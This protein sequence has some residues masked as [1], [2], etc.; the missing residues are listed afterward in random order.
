ME[1][2]FHGSPDLLRHHVKEVDHLVASVAG[3]LRALPQSPPAA[4]LHGDLVPANVL[5]QGGRVTGVLNFGFLTAVG[6][7][8]FDAAITASIF[9]MYGPTHVLQRTCWVK[10]SPPDSVTTWTDTVSIVLRTPSSHIPALVQ[11]VLTATSCGALRCFG[12]RT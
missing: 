5:V 2:R 9:D 6:D 4:L 8:Q 10:P 12:A 11:M 1:R 3:G 7:P